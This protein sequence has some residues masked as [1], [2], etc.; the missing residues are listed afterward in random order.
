MSR[1]THPGKTCGRNVR[2]GTPLVRASALHGVSATEI[3][4]R[5][6][7]LDST[8]NPGRAVLTGGVF[9]R[10]GSVACI[11]ADASP[12]EVLAPTIVDDQTGCRQAY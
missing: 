1:N 9:R 10:S 11:R 7:H 6:S 5:G 8:L 12:S 2:T 3:L 4:G